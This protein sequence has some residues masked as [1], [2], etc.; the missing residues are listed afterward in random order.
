MAFDID[1]LSKILMNLLSNAFKHTPQ[2]GKV[3]VIVTADSNETLHISVMDYGCGIPDKDKERIF[4]RFYQNKCD[5]AATMGC[6]VGLHIVKEYVMLHKG[7]IKV[8]DN[9][10]TGSI[11]TISLP[12]THTDTQSHPSQSQ[13]RPIE[14]SEDIESVDA[15][16]LPN[17]KHTIMIVEDNEEFLDFLNQSLSTEYT[18]LTANNG[19][20]ALALLNDS[21]TVD[22]VI[23]DVMMDRM[24]GI[25][26]CRSI[27]TDLHYSH[28][29]V[30]LLTAKSMVEDEIQGFEVGADDYITKPFNLSVLKLR[31]QNILKSR[32]RYRRIFKTQPDINPSEITITSLDEQF[33]TKALAIVEDNISNTEFSVEDLSTSLGMHRAHLYR[34]LSGITGKTPV[35][36]IRLIRLKRARQYLEKSQMYI[37]EIAYAVGFNSPKLFAKYFKEEFGMSP[38]DY[39]NSHST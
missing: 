37:S 12:I 38:R 32:D 14:A 5:N 34:K 25:E 24:D 1:K 2:G 31:I 15:T 39:Q 22:I 17:D 26:L 4:E 9:N 7:T 13:N 35:E 23:S 10:P 6:G 33:I 19:E 36:F 21:P 27:K 30:I 8:T 28:I 18:V 3:F 20:E 11:F 29:P 16:T